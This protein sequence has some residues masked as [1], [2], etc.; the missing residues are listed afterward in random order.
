MA[1][2]NASA[3]ENGILALLANQWATR[4]EINWSASNAPFRTSG[5]RTS[6]TDN[7]TYLV[8]RLQQVSADSLEYPVTS[9][10]KKYDYQFNLNL[11]T[12]PALGMGHLQGHL[13]ELR[14]IFELQTITLSGTEV[15]FEVVRNQGGFLSDTGD[16]FELP[17]SVF[18]TSYL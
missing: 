10:T 5:L 11:I 14:D 3:L 17:V 8:P 6:F 12:R 13:N 4:T 18:F 15:H 1:L 7:E 2:A 9:A 16:S